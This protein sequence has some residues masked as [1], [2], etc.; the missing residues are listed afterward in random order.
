MK[1]DL[2]AVAAAESSMQIDEV[3]YSGVCGRDTGRLTGIA[4][5]TPPARE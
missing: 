5:V 1:E 4:G 3:R 2:V